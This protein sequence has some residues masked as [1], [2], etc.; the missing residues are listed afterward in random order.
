[1]A[2]TKKAL[3]PVFI[4]A[5]GA[6]LL[7]AEDKKG[8]PLDQKEVITIRDKSAAIML[9][10]AD[11]QKM[12][13]SRGYKDIDP[14]NCWHDFQKL[15]DDLGRK[16][17]LDPG[18]RFDKIR[19]S[20]DEFKQ[21]AVCAQT[22]LAVFRVWLRN[23]SKNSDATL[24]FKTRL[25]DDGKGAFMWLTGAREVGD[26]FAGILFEVPTSFRE[27]RV[28]DEITVAS[29]QIIDWM[30]NDH[31]RVHGGFSI[32]VLRQRKPESEH[33][34]FDRVMGVSSYAPLPESV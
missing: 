21:A 11:A 30:V 15:R 18:P 8:S 17:S 33:A 27:H 26:G 24:M 3:V 31:G 28:G 6:V 19:D 16:P 20:D 7:A 12:D 13:E 9:E 25:I 1:M 22:T 10:L 2:E 29:G 4:P 23:G 34:Q 32:R 5:L 14:E